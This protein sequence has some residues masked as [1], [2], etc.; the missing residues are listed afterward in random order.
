MLSFLYVPDLFLYMGG[1]RHGT[2]KFLKKD[3]DELGVISHCHYL[4]F[5]V[6]Q[7]KI[8]VDMYKVQVQVLWLAR[9]S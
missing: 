5:G 1:H 6:R 7:G 3:A 2:L 8:S 4:E 9:P